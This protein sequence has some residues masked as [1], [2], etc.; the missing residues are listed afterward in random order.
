MNLHTAVK[1]VTVSVSHLGLTEVVFQN[2]LKSLLMMK[3]GG[4]QGSQ[5]GTR[6]EVE[7]SSASLESSELLANQKGEGTTMGGQKV[8]AKRDRR[9]QATPVRRG[10]V[11]KKAPQMR[12][13]GAVKEIRKCRKSTNLLIPKL[14]FL[15]LV[16]QIAMYVASNSMQG[17]RYITSSFI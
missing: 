17:F 15:R 7:N 16:K 1:S 2:S 13:V 14:H 8:A 3:R 12:G 5:A 10:C 11:Q 9:K 4:G 6:R